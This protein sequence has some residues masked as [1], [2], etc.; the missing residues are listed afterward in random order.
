MTGAVLNGL[1]VTLPL[2]R[3]PYR[4]LRRDFFRNNYYY[5]C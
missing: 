2:T 5:E 1:S 4:E 3:Y